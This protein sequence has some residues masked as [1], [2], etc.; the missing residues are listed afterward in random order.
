MSRRLSPTVEESTDSSEPN[1]R[2]QRRSVS[3]PVSPRASFGNLKSSP[4]RRRD[5]SMTCFPKLPSRA[6]T[7]DWLTPLGLFGEGN[8]SQH[9]GTMSDLYAH[10]VDAHPGTNVP[11]PLEI[12]E[13]S[14]RQTPV[15]VKDFPYRENLSELPEIRDTKIGGAVGI[16]SHRRKSNF[17]TMEAARKSEP[18]HGILGTLRR[19]SFMPLSDQT[20]E[21]IR[22][23][24][25]PLLPPADEFL[26]RAEGARKSNSKE[27]LQGILEN[28]N[29]RSSSDRSSRRS[30]KK[31]SKSYFRERR[32]RKTDSLTE[33]KRR[34]TTRGRMSCSEDQTPHICMDEQMTP[35][36]DLETALV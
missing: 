19:Y 6:S 26:L 18:S 10:G 24:S 11:R 28:S 36:S 8:L 32:R 31:S 25:Q 9:R 30:S 27:L 23:T 1:L 5:G 17:K 34:S 22:E 20:P 3:E 33:Q 16:A 21:S 14:P 15:P 2:H 29:M 35:L 12:L 4:A 7:S 13:E